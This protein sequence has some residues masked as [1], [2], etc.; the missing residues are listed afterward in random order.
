MIPLSLQPISQAVTQ[1]MV[2]FPPQP[3]AQAIAQRM[4]TVIT[5]GFTTE[6]ITQSIEK[7]CGIRP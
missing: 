6:V 1:R 2:A 3:L 7:W 5:A 4:P